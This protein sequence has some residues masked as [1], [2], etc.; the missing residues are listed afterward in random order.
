MALLPCLKC[1]K[2]FGDWKD[3]CPHCNATNF[4]RQSFIRND[5]VLLREATSVVV[6]Q[7]KYENQVKH[8]EQLKELK[9]LQPPISFWQ[10]VWY[11]F[12]NSSFVRTIR[13]HLWE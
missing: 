5:P 3:N 4:F 10:K 8:R 7:I 6:N 13:Q 1:D 11:A 9:K 2:T 12:S